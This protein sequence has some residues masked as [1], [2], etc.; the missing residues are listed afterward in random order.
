MF[1]KDIMSK[2]INC[3][4]PEDTV[5]KF[6]SFVQENNIQSVLLMDNKKLEGVLDIKQLMRKG[7]TDPSKFKLKN[8][9]KGKAPSLSPEDDFEKAAKL[10]LE[11]DLRELPVYDG[12]GVIGTLSIS[13]L[14]ENVTSSKQ[15]RQTTAG[16]IMS[17]IESVNQDDDIGKVRQMMREKNISRIP[18][19]DKDGNLTGI[20]TTLDLLKSMKPRERMDFYSMAAEMEQV[21]RMPVSIVMD[22][23]VFT[24]NSEDNLQDIYKIMK[25]N[26]RASVVIS[27][28][29]KPEGIIV[30]KDLLEFYL[31]SL[32]GNEITYQMIG[33][34]DESDYVVKS[35][36]RSVQDTIKKL[37][38]V[39]DPQFLFIHVKKHETGI[40]SRVKYSIRVRFG[41]GK[42]IFMTQACDWDLVA[43]VGDAMNKLEKV[44]FRSKDMAR[45]IRKHDMR[46]EKDLTKM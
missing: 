6:V 33:I 12:K 34:K 35:V 19:T 7:I 10:L 2:N 30:L 4:S 45:D 26:K 5:S 3:L 24:A 41:T 22:K 36:E 23:K 31:G 18:V 39:Y 32:K 42:G 13:D 43:A 28:N 44:M 11:S 37:S 15:F 14:V 27:K 1:V 17:Q 21:M 20:V 9:I 16:T 46:R 40:K 8:L 25:R 38:T 29:N